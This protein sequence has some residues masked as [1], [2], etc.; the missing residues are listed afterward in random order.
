MQTLFRGTLWLI[1]VSASFLAACGGGGGGSNTSSKPEL[2]VSSP[3]ITEGDTG[4]S[5]LDFV[6]S[7]SRAASTDVTVDYATSDGSAT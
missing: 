4:T 2:T 3:I 6:V 1:L 5:S 7:L